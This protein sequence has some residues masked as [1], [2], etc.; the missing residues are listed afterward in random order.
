MLTPRPPQVEEWLK[1][2]DY[3]GDGNIS[4]EEFKFALNGNSAIDC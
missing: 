3:N 2:T 4:Y 1:N